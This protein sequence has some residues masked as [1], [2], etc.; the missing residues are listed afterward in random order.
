[1]NEMIERVARALHRD[2]DNYGPVARELAILDARKA[3]EAMR[4]PTEA[5]AA[6]MREV[7]DNKDRPPTKRWHWVWHEMIEAALA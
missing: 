4:E 2:I 6:V 1:M 7:L 5:Q 3:I